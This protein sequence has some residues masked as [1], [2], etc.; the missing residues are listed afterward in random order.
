[1]LVKRF[2][3][4]IRADNCKLSKPEVALYHEACLQPLIS[5][6]FVVKLKRLEVAYSFIHVIKAFGIDILVVC[7]Q[8]CSPVLRHRPTHLGS[9]SSPLD[10]VEVILHVSC[11]G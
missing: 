4:K 8:G 10:A 5:S 11:I 6:E 9:S 7:A 2:S 1:M 3:I